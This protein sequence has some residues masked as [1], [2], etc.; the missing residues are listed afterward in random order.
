MIL[1]PPGF[2]G[3]V[4][5]RGDFV[6]R[7]VPPALAVP[8]DAWLGMLTTAVRESAGLDWP[9]V[10]LTAPVWHFTLGRGVSPGPGAAGVL[11]ASVDRVGRFFPFTIIGPARGIPDA[12]WSQAIEDLILG[13]LDDGFDPDV[14]DAELVRLGPPAGGEVMEAG[15]SLWRCRGSDRVGP[16]SATASGLPGRDASA[17]MVLGPTDPAP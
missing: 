16:T 5:A 3:K 7:R 12:A 13:A 9:E 1:E 6:S 17:A 2:F 4:P 11:V 15:Q 8:W 10:W 14:L